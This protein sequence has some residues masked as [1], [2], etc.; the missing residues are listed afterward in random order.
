MR[1]VHKLGLA[2]Q[3]ARSWRPHYLFQNGQGGGLYL[4]LVA[5]QETALTTPADEAGETIAAIVDQKTATDTFTTF[6]TSD[7]S[8]GVDGWA[9]TNGVSAGGIDGVLGRDDCLR[10]T[11]GATG[12]TTQTIRAFTAYFASGI[13]CKTIM[14][15][16]VPA[17]QT[18]VDG[19]Q[20]YSGTNTTGTLVYDGANNGSTGAWIDIDVTGY[21]S[22]STMRVYPYDGTSNSINAAASGE[23]L[24]MRAIVTSYTNLLNWWMPTAASQPRMGILPKGRTVRNRSTYTND[25]TQWGTPTRTTVSANQILAPDGIDMADALLETAAVGTHF[26]SHTNQMFSYV[27]GTTYTRSQWLRGGLGRQYVQVYF[28][29]EGFVN[30]ERTATF[31]T[32]NKTVFSTEA[33]VTASVL[34]LGSDGWFRVRI[35]CVSNETI[36][37]HVGGVAG[38][39]DDGTTTS[40]LGVVTK[41]VY[42]WG[43][44]MEVASSASALQ[45][46]GGAWDVTESGY[47]NVMLPYGDGGDSMSTG[48]V[49]FGTATQGLYAA[50]GQNWSAQVVFCTFSN[51]ATIL[52]QC[53]STEANKQL[54]A[55]TNSANTAVEVCVR[56]TRT[57]LTGTYYPGALNLLSLVC[58]NGV[59]TARVNTSAREA[60]GIG[61][62]A[63][64]AVATTFMARTATSPSTFLTGWALPVDLADYAMSAAVESQAISTIR[65]LVGGP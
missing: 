62:A 43:E 31:D 5:Y 30:N 53:G 18:Y 13:R 58:T 23:L 2:F 36:S 63:A 57:V 41:G 10:F 37:G 59:V 19:F 35:T 20:V 38:V 47:P 32:V 7:F 17:G 1:T 11:V 42:A 25:L 26:L 51:S 49:G 45:V 48:V 8:A 46:V 24:Y 4:P 56:G 64:E 34:E 61:A 39:A 40:Y 50:A 12:G 16:Y 29:A 52:A 14:S 44:Q 28:P 33:N 54:Q 6:Y 3:S 65:S 27:N 9:D 15:V 60:V 21:V 55:N 22:S